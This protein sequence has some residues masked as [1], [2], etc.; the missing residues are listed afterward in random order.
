MR[1]SSDGFFP[2]PGDASFLRVA[3]HLGTRDDLEHWLV[4]LHNTA[5][6]GGGDGMGCVAR[7]LGYL[8]HGGGSFLDQE[9]ANHFLVPNFETTPHAHVCVT[10]IQTRGLSLESV[11]C[12]RNLPT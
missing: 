1:E 8:A 10:I 3:P 12:D 7:I 2:V 5:G 6:W 9:E 11:W 4:R